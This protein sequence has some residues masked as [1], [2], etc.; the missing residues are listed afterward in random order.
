MH[1]VSWFKINLKCNQKF[2]T[3]NVFRYVVKSC[4]KCRDSDVSL[5]LVGFQYVHENTE[6]S[7]QS[8]SSKQI[9]LLQC[10]IHFV[11]GNGFLHIFLELFICKTFLS[12]S[13]PCEIFCLKLVFGACLYAVSHSGSLHT[14]EQT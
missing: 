6:F 10:Y 4:M 1:R 3:E 13:L 14:Y 7:L 12:L 2:S 8:F 9:L 5:I 11:M